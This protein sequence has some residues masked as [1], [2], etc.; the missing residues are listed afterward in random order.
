M[1]ASSCPKGVYTAVSTPL[2]KDGQPDIQRFLEHC[3]WLLNIG[4]DGLAPLGTTG[5][6]NSL[7]MEQ[8]LRMIEAIGSSDL[9]KQRLI[10]GTGST[11]IEETVLASQAAL[12][13]GAG[14]LLMLPP[15]YYKNPSEDGLFNYFAA[16]A[17]GLPETA[18]IFLY[19][20]PQMSN[21]PITVE[22]V[23]RLRH[24]HPGMF[25]GLKDSSGDFSNTSA[26]LRNFPG[27]Q[28]FAGS[29][30]LAVRTLEAGGWG[31]I[32]ATAN[33]SAPIVARR[34]AVGAGPEG[35]ELDRQITEVRAAISAKGNVSATKA[36]MAIYRN[37]PEWARTAPPNVELN[38]TVA[39]EL[40]SELDRIASLRRYFAPDSTEAN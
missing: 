37:D 26:F 32:S 22:L 25:V 39:Q 35:S 27:F 33:L 40:A 17:N 16:V 5:E 4:C 20:F 38:E 28:V 18:R 29:E 3:R 2:L 15:Y 36:V 19:H 34:I 1:V 13:A 24:S 21:V 6:A 14:G 9:P 23:R 10:I 31:C 8:R 11:S 30:T 7:G 12:K